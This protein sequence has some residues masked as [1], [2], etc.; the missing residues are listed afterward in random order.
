MIRALKVKVDSEKVLELRDS[1]ASRFNV[2]QLEK[3]HLITDYDLFKREN[4][5]S[6]I[7]HKLFYDYTTLLVFKKWYTKFIRDEVLP[8]LGDEDGLIYQTTPTFRVHLVGNRAVGE[9]HTDR[10]YGH[11]D[12][13]IN[14]W[15]PLTEARNFNTVWVEKTKGLNRV[16]PIDVAFGQMLVFDGVSFLHGNMVNSDSNTRV[17]MDFR[18]VPARQF[19]AQEEQSINTGMKF[20][21]GDYFSY[22]RK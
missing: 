15:L 7:W 14:C 17:S 21:V 3:L 18:V 2:R 9:F 20:Q 4:D 10:T 8:V 5:Q 13:E 22:M 16:E 1:L 11:S 12:Q 6:T 19:V